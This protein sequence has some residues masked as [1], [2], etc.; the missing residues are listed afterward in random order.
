MKVFVDTSY[1]VA[2]LVARDQWHDKALKGAR[3]DMTFVTSSL[4]S[5]L[6]G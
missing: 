4:A 1:Y 2:I 5:T 3:P 6:A